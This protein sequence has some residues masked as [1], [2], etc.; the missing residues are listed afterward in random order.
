VADLGESMPALEIS[1]QK[2]REWGEQWLGTTNPVTGKEKEAACFDKKQSVNFA[3]FIDRAFAEALAVMLGGV[4]IQKARSKDLLPAKPDC[5]E[6]GNVKVIGGVRPQLFDVGYRPDGVRVA[7]DSKTLND[8]KS[9]KKNWQ[10]M[11][12]DLATEAANVHTR[13]P[14]AVV[15]FVVVIP[16]PALAAKQATDMVRTLERL[17]T[18]RDVLDQTH[19]AEVISMLVWDPETGRISASVPPADSIIRIERHSERLYPHYLA[20]YKGLPP[21]AKKAE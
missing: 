14:Y 20:R 10:N 7:F 17:G 19:L 6:T 16:E 3:A 18:R 4:P 9:I 1:Q 11:I 15:S 5:V 2:L 21:H 12:N 13:Y 8:R